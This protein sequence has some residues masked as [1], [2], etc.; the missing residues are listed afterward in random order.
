MTKEFQ[1]FEQRKQ[2]HITLALLAENQCSDSNCF[3]QLQLEH[4]ALP[5]LN[6]SDI[7]ISTQRF[8]KKVPKPFFVSSMTAGH[9]NAKSINRRLIKACASTGWAMGVGSQRRELSDTHAFF[10]WTELRRDFPDVELYSNLGIAQLITTPI[11]KINKIIASLQAN[12][13]II[14]CNPLQECMQPEGTTEYKG[15]WNALERLRKNCVL[16]IIVKETGCGFSKTTITRL[17]DVGIAALDI[18]GLGGTHWGRIEGM[19]AVDDIIRHKAAQTFKDWGIDT[20]SS[21]K[22]AMSLK[23]NFEIWG[24]GGVLNGLNAAKLLALGVNS[25]GFAK[26]M[27]EPALDSTQAVITAM[28]TIEYELKIAM[29]CTGSNEIKNLHTKIITD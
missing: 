10:E 22:H 4:D 28:Q 8:S 5:D 6:F 15:C 11:D 1:Q 17:Q 3:N 21:V 29:F 16:P 14:H 13:L 20:V 18:S 7:D 12:A 27:L 2:E 23:P 25:V 19:R 26:P 24:S 9:K